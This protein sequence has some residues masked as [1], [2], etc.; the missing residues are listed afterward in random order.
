[1]RNWLKDHLPDAKSINHYAYFKGLKKYLGNPCLWRFNEEA[2][3]RGCGIG[4]F[5]AV[6]PLIP[7]QILIAV[8]LAIF[9]RGNLPIAFLISWI[10]NPL[11]Y[12]PIIYFVNYVGNS[13]LGASSVAV[14]AQ[15]MKWNFD[16]FS[17]FWHSLSTWIFQYS[18]N[19]LLGL[20]I[21]SIVAAAGGYI[22]VKLI[23]TIAN[24]IKKDW[25]KRRRR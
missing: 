22:I 7:F 19:Y 15:G 6:L 9:L 17:T 13:I 10:S 24:F 4:L 5:V 12:F 14:I 2:V 11:T 23:Y 1:M 16:N 25:K 3:A 21:V 8:F 18:K 20:V